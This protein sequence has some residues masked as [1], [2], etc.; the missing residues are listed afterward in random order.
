MQL[1]FTPITAQARIYIAGHMGLVGSALWRHFADLGFEHLIGCSSQDLD[2]RDAHATA[3]FFDE[4]RPEVVIAAAARVGGIAANSSRPAEFISDNLR[5]QVNLLDSSL[6][7]GVSRFLFLGSS[8]IYPKF[9]AQPIRED[10]LLTGPLEPTNEAFAAAKIAGIAHVAS[11]RRQHHLP[12]ISAMVTNIYG[13][14]DNFDP[15]DSHV[16]S[17]MIRRFHEAARDDVT[18]VTCWGTGRPRRDFMHVDD[19]AKACHFL[20]D[21]Y[22]DDRPINV[23]TG[24]DLSIAELAHLVASV[25]GYCGEVKW[26]VSKPD[27]APRKLLDTQRL[28]ELGWKPE[29]PI[30]QGIQTTYEWFLAHHGDIDAN[31]VCGR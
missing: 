15:I 6:A 25:V 9:A 2:L 4:T 23:G 30:A 19:F 27:G 8:C 10:A 22:D 3:A 18:S 20:L 21:H 26:D 7:T 12:Y 29:T 5:I 31:S 17:A 24:Q 1:G 14:G 16:I 13:P 28:D 11:I